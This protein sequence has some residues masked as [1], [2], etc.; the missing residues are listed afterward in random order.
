MVSTAS[1]AV[2]AGQVRAYTVRRPPETGSA[3]R[4]GDAAA[5]HIRCN[6]AYGESVVVSV[7]PAQGRPNLTRGSGAMFVGGAVKVGVL[8][9]G[10]LF[11]AVACAGRAGS[12][13]TINAGSASTP[14]PPST[15][16]TSGIASGAA[17][18]SRGGA[19]RTED[20]A[21]RLGQPSSAKFQEGTTIELA[22]TGVACTVAGYLGLRLLDSSGAPMPTTVQQL[23]DNATAAPVT[24]AQGGRAYATLV[25]N[26]YEG[27]GTLCRPY[28][29]SIAVSLPGDTAAVTTPWISGDEGSACQG[30]LSVGALRA[31]P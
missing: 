12:T 1:G 4:T 27:Q 26:K 17:S 8:A 7:R 29:A 9:A 14:P 3:E 15:S 19:C 16:A 21:V 30:A 22:N 23:P 28:P 24:L 10:V 18:G 31:T 20:L 2:P 5:E 6:R 25:W 13:P 11:A